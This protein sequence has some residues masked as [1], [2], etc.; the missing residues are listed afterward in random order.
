MGGFARVKRPHDFNLNR[1]VGAAGIS[2]WID[3]DLQYVRTGPLNRFGGAAAVG[4]AS[5][6]MMTEV[7]GLV[8]LQD[9]KA[10]LKKIELIMIAVVLK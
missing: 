10:F 2:P 5:L 6:L 7:F 3:A 1:D 9:M 4:A 8:P